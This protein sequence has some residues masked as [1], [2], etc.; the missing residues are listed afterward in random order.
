M[1]ERAQHRIG[2]GR[3]QRATRTTDGSRSAGSQSWRTSRHPRG[4]RVTRRVGTK[5]SKWERA[6]S[7]PTFWILAVLYVVLATGFATATANV[8]HSRS[9][10]VTISSTH[11]V[12]FGPQAK[13]LVLIV[14][15]GAR[16]DY[17][18]LTRL[19][20][21]DALRAEGVQYVNAM[22]G[23]LETE[24]PSGHTAISTGSTP[25][26]NGILGFD[27]AQNDNDYSLFSPDVVR[28]GAIE[29]I[30]DVGHVPTIAGLF[31]HKYPQAR[32][33]ALS[34]HKY[35]AADPLGGP[36]ADAIMYYQGSSDGHYV[37]VAIPGHV[38]PQGVMDAPGLIGQST[39]LGY[40]GEDTLATRLA[41]SAFKTMKQRI[42]MI[43][44]PEFDWPAGH[45][46][47]GNKNPAKVIELMRNFDRDLG[48]LKAAYRKAGVLKQTMFVITA[49]HGMSPLRRF[50]PEE[51]FTKAVA[52]AGTTSPSASYNTA[53]Y[54][55]LA[56]SN[57]SQAVAQNILKA[58]DPGIQSV[59]YLQTQGAATHY[60]H[61]GGDFVQPTVDSSNQYLLNTLMNGHEPQVVAFC[62]TDQSAANPTT[63]WLADH[64]GA[65]WQSQHIPLIL[66]GPGVASGQIEMQPAQL[67]DIAP[68][69]LTNMGVKP[70][71]MEGHVLTEALL[72]SSPPDQRGRQ[73]E[74]T[75]IN[76]LVQAMIA[77]DAAEVGK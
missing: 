32:V 3:E 70:T 74:S 44:Y 34:G 36:Q 63:H 35:Y 43:N 41:I 71:G 45:V 15:D 4:S 76:P 18:G 52:A 16:P 51:V 62:K 33:V 27:W 7:S 59:Y 38:P 73:E 64:G 14:L 75:Q 37:P 46:D 57:K 25:A 69:V 56:D 39:H 17:F 42:T 30:M 1:R 9:N 29:H 31:K 77:Q 67:V 58:N 23:I 12:S 48:M 72:N 47:G 20:N 49:D 66:A 11:L 22:D 68:T 21:V 8:L 55:W 19:P 40:G 53:T 26:R 54:L 6:R 61:A 60:V 24:T 10:A 5:T 28:S 65:N 13:Y 2:G 50:V